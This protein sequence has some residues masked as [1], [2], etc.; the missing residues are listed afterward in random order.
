M[1]YGG[2]IWVWVMGYHRLWVMG[3]FLA[4]TKSVDPKMYGLLPTMGYLGM[5]YRGFDCS[6]PAKSKGHQKPP[7]KPW[8]LTH[9]CAW[10]SNRVA[11]PGAADDTGIASGILIEGDHHSSHSSS[12]LRSSHRSHPGK[13]MASQSEYV[14]GHKPSHIQHHA[15]R[16]AENSAQYLLPHLIKRA[17]EKPT[18][19]LLD[20]GAGPGTISVSLA[21]Y[22]P[23]GAVTATDISDEVLQLAKDHANS[24]GCTNIRFQIADVYNLPFPDN[25]FDIVH[26]SQ[27]L[28]HLNDPVKALKE[29]IR[30]CVPGGIVADR[31]A[32]M[33]SCYFYPAMPALRDFFNLLDYVMPRNNTGLSL[34]SFAMQAGVPRA[35]ILFTSSSH[36]CGTLEERQVFGSACR[37][38]ASAGGMRR[39]AL[40]E[41]LRTAEQMDEMAK[42]WDQWIEAEDACIACINGE[43]VITKSA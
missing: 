21:K 19:Q 6:M 14:P 22:T 25:S 35:D 10:S 4:G 28:A 31:E 20:V 39:K 23:Q 3:P 1:G 9:S 43:I 16:T 11:R 5:C 30:V 36:S 12:A 41:G 2:S 7:H 27:V 18:L 34:I 42:A 40:E 24:L 33:Q 38:R 17:Q 37:E 8:S 15:S 26:V 13:I 29:L 32:E